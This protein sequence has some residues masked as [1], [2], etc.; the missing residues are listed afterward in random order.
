MVMFYGRRSTVLPASSWPNRVGLLVTAWCASTASTTTPRCR[1]PGCCIVP[2]VWGGLTL[3]VRGTAYLILTVALTAAAMAYLP[4]E[5]VRVRRPAPGRVDHRPAGDRQRRLRAAAEPDA[6]AARLADRRARPQ[7]R[8]VGGAATDAGD[9]LQLDERRRRPARRSGI[10][11]YNTA[12]RQLL[13]RPILT[14]QAPLLGRRHSGSATPEGGPLRRGRAA[15][16]PVP[17]RSPRRPRSRSRSGSVRTALRASSSSRL[18][19]SATATTRS[20]MVLLHDVTS[21][22]ARLR[23]LSNFAGMVAHDLRGPLTVLDGWLEVVQDGDGQGRRACRRGRPGQGPG[24]EPADASGD[25]GLAELHGRPERAAAPG[26][27]KLASVAAEIVRSRRAQLG[28]WRRAPVHP[29][30]RAQRP[31]RPRAAPAAAGQPRR[32]T[33]SSTRPPT[34]RPG[35]GRLGAGQRAGLGHGARSP[36]TASGCRRVRRSRSSRSST[37]GRPRVAPPAR[38]SASRSPAGSSPPHGGELTARRNPEGG[39][40]FTF[41]LPEA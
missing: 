29:R 26:P 14:G 18:S 41:T 5:P 30:P 13:G 10:T 32:R 9:R 2:S 12:A 11:M 23:E 16:Q 15:R 31:G 36:T 28:R 21:Q 27:V 40:T 7:G 17:P 1:C 6:R 3:T 4:A 24:R 38:A 22:R 37:A 20:T 39:S 34:R 8:G 25:R 33:R 35:C 19:R